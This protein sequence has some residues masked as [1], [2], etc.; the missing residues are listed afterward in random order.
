[1]PAF[2]PVIFTKKCIKFHT[3]M[4]KSLH[5]INNLKILGTINKQARKA[6]LPGLRF[7]STVLKPL[8]LKNFWFC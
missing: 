7:C 6:N 8:F 3:H 5:I 4:L 2:Y 1:L